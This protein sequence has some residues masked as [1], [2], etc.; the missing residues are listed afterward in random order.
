M[1]NSRNKEEITMFKTNTSEAILHFPLK[2][3]E[4]VVEG[5]FYEVVDGYAQAVSG[6]PTGN[7]V[8]VCYGGG[9]KIEKGHILL[10]VDPTSIYEE[11]YTDSAPTI[12]SILN[13]VKLVVSVNE[14]NKTYRFMK[15]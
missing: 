11:S 5:A 8:G 6:E 10:D 12:G 4:E 13:Y 15:P 9:D 2:E 1:K 7:I 14:A 3:G